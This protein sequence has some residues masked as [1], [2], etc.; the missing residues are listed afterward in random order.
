MTTT[1]R[2]HAE[3]KGL[4]GLFERFPKSKNP[5]DAL[6]ADSGGIPVSEPNLDDPSTPP[7]PSKRP[8]LV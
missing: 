3:E 8:L 4:G 2:Y 1:F 5:D 6:P 7:D